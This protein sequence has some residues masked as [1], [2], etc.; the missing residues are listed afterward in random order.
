MSPNSK[1]QLEDSLLL[2]NSVKWFPSNIAHEL[3]NKNLRD[4]LHA[5]LLLKAA[6]S[7]SY[8]IIGTWY[9]CTGEPCQEL[10]KQVLSLLATTFSSSFLQAEQIT[11]TFSQCE[12]QQHGQLVMHASRKEHVTPLLC[13]LFGLPV[14][15]Q[16]LLLTSKALSGIE[17]GYLRTSS[18]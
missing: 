2:E 17:P 7:H 12:M 8:F 10:G 3:G 1:E 5:K 4:H 15:F 11:G 14:C 18:S 13:E 9:K 16:V 6:L